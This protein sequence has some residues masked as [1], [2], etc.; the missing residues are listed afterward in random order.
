M[1]NTINK[2]FKSY[3]T[4]IY[5]SFIINI[6]LIFYAYGIKTSTNMY[7]FSGS[8]TYLSVSDGVVAFTKDMSYI[9]GNNIAYINKEDYDIKKY[10]I[11]Y[12]VKKE[13]NLT[14]IISTNIDLENDIKLSSLIENLNIF[15]LYEPKK[16]TNVF[17][18]ETKDLIED[19]LYLILE[20][21][22][23]DDETIQS[24]IK[25]NVSRITN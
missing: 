16:E 25:L 3:K 23:K 22:T 12:Y 2:I 8:D 20:A 11:G 17:T 21:T 13:S 9:N 19:G 18:K 24:E 7:V 4:I 14:E 10:K 1:K 6:I 15:S 5:I